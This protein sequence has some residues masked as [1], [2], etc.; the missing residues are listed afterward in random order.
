MGRGFIIPSV[1]LV[2]IMQIREKTKIRTF[3]FDN[4]VSFGKRDNLYRSKLPLQVCI[5]I[6]IVLLENIKNNLIFLFFIF[7]SQQETRN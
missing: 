4:L 5:F 3:N 2:T 1:H 7:F 6:V